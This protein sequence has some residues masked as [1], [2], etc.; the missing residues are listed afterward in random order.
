MGVSLQFV[1]NQY[2]KPASIPQSNIQDSIAD[3]EINTKIAKVGV[4][5][6]TEANIQETETLGSVT[7]YQEN[8]NLVIASL[9]IDDHQ[10]IS[11]AQIQIYQQINYRDI[12]GMRS[13]DEIRDLKQQ[14]I[15]AAVEE[16]IN[17]GLVNP[18]GI[19]WYTAAYDLQLSQRGINYHLAT[20]L[21]AFEQC[22]RGRT[23]TDLEQYFQENSQCREVLNTL[24]GQSFRKEV[25]IQAV[26][27][28][29]KQGDSL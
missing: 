18:C 10:Q 17:A 6:E 27:N 1:Y 28:A 21:K 19:N 29:F 14:E 11:D 20:A 7:F 12:N 3:E 9:I 5:M 13:G 26:I 15:M 8:T 23:L 24:E 22:L 25:Y 2:K 16:E 4:S